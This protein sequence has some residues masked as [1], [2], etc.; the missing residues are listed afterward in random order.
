MIQYARSSYFYNN[1]YL[2]WS[3]ELILILC[4]DEN[5]SGSCQQILIYTGFRRMARIFKKIFIIVSVKLTRVAARSK[6]DVN[7]E[8]M[9]KIDGTASS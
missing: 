4:V 2:L 3:K 5:Q 6:F 9:L 1:V 8:D 7:R